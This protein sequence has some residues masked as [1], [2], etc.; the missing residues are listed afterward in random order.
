ME[1]R[2]TAMIAEFAANLL[3]L[4]MDA[5]PFLLF[6]LLLAGAM[7]AWIPQTLLQRHLG[8]SGP[9][10]VI[11]AALIGT[12]LP[13]CSC[14][15]LPV[16]LGL[17]ANGAS[18]G[19]T[20][21]FLVATPET[22]VDSI[23]VS[24]ALLGPIMAV[25][26]PIAAVISAIS[27]GLLAGWHDIGEHRQT[28]H[29]KQCCD[30]H[31]C[32]DSQS[33]SLG[34][35]VHYSLT[36]MLDDIALWLVVGLVFAALVKTFLPPSWLAE[37]GSG[38]PAMLVMVAIGVPMYI[39]ASASTP[40]AA[41]LM[42]AGISPGTALVFLLAGPATNIATVGVVGRELGRRA[43]IGYL[44]GVI[45]SSILMGLLLDALLNAQQINLATEMAEAGELL[46]EWLAMGSLLV[47][48]ACAIKPLRRQL[49]WL[50]RD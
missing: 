34:E 16:A 4:S 46:P 27:A 1:P 35:G 25:V 32:D 39:C 12:P 13:M 44:T 43:V 18:R 2:V 21:S 11:K 3:A 40:I 5:A 30:Q 15:V 20:V 48:A 28:E 37:W 10:P 29:D 49:P 36:Q 33:Q 7:K 8:G 50:G 41:G 23:S 19:S 47:L 24:Y 22:G 31:G 38:L 45:V 42:M 26:R 6:G 14:G 9:I 17:R